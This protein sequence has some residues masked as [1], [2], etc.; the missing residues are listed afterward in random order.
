MMG[1]ETNRTIEELFESLLQKFWKGL[2]E[3]L[4]GSELFF[5]SVD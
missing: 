3:K 4:R 5:D 2:E 1:N